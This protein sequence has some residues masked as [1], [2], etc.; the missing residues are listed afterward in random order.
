M[1]RQFQRIFY[2]DP[3]VPDRILD[4]GVSEQ[5]LDRTKIA[6]RLID[7]RGL[8][9]SKRVCSIVLAPQ[10]NRG[11]PFVNKPGILSSAEMIGV[12]DPTG[13]GI[14]IDRSSPPPKPGKH[15]SPDLSRD[16]ELYGTSGLLL[17]DHGTSSNF[18]ACH[19]GSNFDLN[20]IAAAELAV[21]GKIEQRSI[22]YSPL[23]V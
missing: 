7:H 21:D 15:A 16:L 5:N 1:L 8:R 14:V 22:S 3:E 12:V 6:R 4:L 13:E 11:H 10:T 20:E 18:R 17:N 23:S 2:V 19:K 9:T